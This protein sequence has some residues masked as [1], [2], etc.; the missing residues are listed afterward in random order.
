VAEH[1]EAGY[2]DPRKQKE[3]KG[4]RFLLKGGPRDGIVA[5]LYPMNDGW[6]RFDYNGDLYVRPDDVDPYAPVKGKRKDNSNLPFMEY[7]SSP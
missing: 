3:H 6:D 5:R 2:A 1:A 7:V 4:V